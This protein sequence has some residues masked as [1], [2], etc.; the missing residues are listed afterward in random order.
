VAVDATHIYWTNAPDAAHP[1]TPAIGRANLDGTQVDQGFVELLAPSGL[2][3]CCLAQ[4]AIDALPA[5]CAGTD[6]TI[7][8]TRGSDRLRG[9]DDDDVI[10]A[11]GG[12]DTVI[13]LRGDDLVCGR[14]G[15]LIRG[16]GGDDTLRGGSGKDQL[17][18]GGGSNRCRGGKGSDSKHHC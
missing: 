12:D 1:T 17:R 15:D 4:M 7:A 2:D 13:G 9:T 18:G 10:A 3:F 8:G 16:R 5:A 6:A 14:G 11:R